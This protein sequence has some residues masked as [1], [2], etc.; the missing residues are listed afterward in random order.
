MNL[1]RSRTKMATVNYRISDPLRVTGT[2]PTIG[3]VFA[4]SMS[5]GG[6][7]LGNFIWVGLSKCQ[8]NF[9]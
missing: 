2:W 9:G 8:A 1:R 7:V 4:S 6:A 5:R 3:D